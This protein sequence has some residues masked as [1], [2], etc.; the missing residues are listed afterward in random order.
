MRPNIVGAALAQIARDK[1][2]SD[3]LFEVLEVQHLLQAQKLHVTLV[4]SD[5][6]LLA[7]L[8]ASR[9]LHARPVAGER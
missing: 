9:S 2:L 5:A 7:Q 4:P 3:A 8:E 1:T 6:G